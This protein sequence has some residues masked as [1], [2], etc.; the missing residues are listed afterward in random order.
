MSSSLIILSS[1]TTIHGVENYFRSDSTAWVEADSEGNLLLH[2]SIVSQCQDVVIKEILRLYQPAI[3]VESREGYLPLHLAVIHNRTTIAQTLLTVYRQGCYHASRNRELPIHLAAEF[4]NSVELI[5]SLLTAHPASVREPDCYGNLPLHRSIISKL[6]NFEIFISLLEYCLCSIRYPNIDGDLPLHLIVRNG[7]KPRGV[8][9]LCI[10]QTTLNNFTEAC[11]TVNKLGNL[12]IHFACMHP[13]VSVVRTL[14]LFNRHCYDCSNAAGLTPLHIAMLQSNSREIVIT[15][16]QLAPRSAMIPFPNGRFPLHMALEEN[17]DVSVTMT[18]INMI[19]SRTAI[20]L[21]DVHGNLPL[22]LAVSQ[23]PLQPPV[24][25]ALLSIHPQACVVANAVHDRPLQLLLQSVT[26]SSQPAIAYANILYDIVSRY[27][28]AMHESP[29]LGNQNAVEYLRQNEDLP[30]DARDLM[31]RI[32]L[33]AAAN[34]TSISESWRK[35]LHDLNWK[36]RK[37]VFLVHTHALDEII[38][39]PQKELSI[40]IA[41][42]FLTMPYERRISR[43]E[44]LRHVISFI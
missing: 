15:V 43:N 41:M 9:F 13:T 4:T 33:Q 8:D 5:H 38:Y 20:F 7:D 39:D 21:T 34:N 11:T 23:H 42:C 32:I 26:K 24:I 6:E 44:I 19:V 2:Q 29:A 28:D 18:I 30:A 3:H 22:H 35:I 1:Q 16:L 31:L 27:P 37:I 25:R 14:F 17:L 10:F 12:P 36:A 40:L